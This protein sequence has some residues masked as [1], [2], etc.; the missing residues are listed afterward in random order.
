MKIEVKAKHIRAA[1]KAKKD[2]GA[3]F[4]A[5]DFCPIAQAVREVFP[6]AQVGMSRIS[7]RGHGN[8][9]SVDLPV[10]AQKFINAFD[11]D[12]PVKPAAFVIPGLKRP[13]KRVK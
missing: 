9:E 2:K 6:E 12:K 8:G 11:L 10:S 3:L 13:R 5:A 1:R 4:E 7:L